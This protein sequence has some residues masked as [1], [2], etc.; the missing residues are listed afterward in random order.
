MI[1]LR[2]VQKIGPKLNSVVFRATYI[3]GKRIINTE[4][5]MAALEDKERYDC[6]GSIYEFSEGKP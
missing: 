4:L 6:R 3:C 1:P 2:K 5:W